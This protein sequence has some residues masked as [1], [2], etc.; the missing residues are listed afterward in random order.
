MKN[1]FA[2]ASD[3]E[4]VRLAQTGDAAAFEAIYDRHV[5]G[6]S[7]TLASFAGPD[8]D[9]LDD[10]T[11]EVFFRVIE[12][13]ESYEPVRP[14]T[15]WLYTI[16]LNIGRNHARTRSKIVLLEPDELESLADSRGSSRELPD[17]VIELALMREVAKLTSQMR[18]VVSLRI[19]SGLPYGEIGEILGIPEGTARSRMNTALNLLRDR[20][21][22]RP[23]RSNDNERQA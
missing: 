12:R 17:E 20:M 11:Q 1:G 13:I 19:G 15:H 21:G 23:R 4:L 7:R 6:I 3:A 2:E 10:L 22:I 18:D 8:R 5:P 16:A 14:F 9:L